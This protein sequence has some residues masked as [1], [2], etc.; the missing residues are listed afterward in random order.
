[1]ADENGVH[2]LTT[3]QRR[4]NPI[5]NTVLQLLNKIGRVSFLKT[6]ILF[7]PLILMV[8]GEDKRN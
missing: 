7:I 5:F 8:D 4:F 3:V 6:D 1:M 2:I